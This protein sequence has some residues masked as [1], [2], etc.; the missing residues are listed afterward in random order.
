[1]CLLLVLLF[2]NLSCFRRKIFPTWGLHERGYS[3]LPTKGKCKFMYIT[4]SW[5]RQVQWGWRSPRVSSPLYSKQCKGGFP[6][7]MQAKTVTINIQ[8]LEMQDI[9]ISQKE[10][11][12]HLTG[13]IKNGRLIS[14]YICQSQAISTCSKISESKNNYAE[15]KKTDQTKVHI[16]WFI[17]MEF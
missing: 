8:S 15:W 4:T 11:N 16:I 13:K 1:M 3:S 14:V 6:S 10:E 12:Q 2:V 7:R 9:L 17:Y 5:W